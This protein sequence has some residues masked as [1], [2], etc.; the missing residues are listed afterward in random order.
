MGAARAR[1]A[2]A[3]VGAGVTRPVWLLGIDPG[4][5]G[6]AVMLMDDGQGGHELACLVSWEQ[7]RR[8]VDPWTVR[9]MAY[10]E[11]ET[12][13]AAS[14]LDALRHLPRVMPPADTVSVEWPIYGGVGAR[15]RSPRSMVTLAHAAGLAEAMAPH[16]ATTAYHHPEAREWRP[17]VLRIPGATDGEVAKRCAM[18]ATTDHARKRSDWRITGSDVLGCSHEHEAA[19][20]ALWPLFGG[21]KSG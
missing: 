3:R 20:I 17:A 7:T 11:V 10:H 12:V 1:L 9:V 4:L 14:L 2:S 13:R 18:E 16:H 19:C 21:S 5:T 8:R 15:R 6:A